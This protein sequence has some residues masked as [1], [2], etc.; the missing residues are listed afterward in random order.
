MYQS[1]R[2][3]MQE[4]LHLHHQGRKTLRSGNKPRVL[5][6]EPKVLIVFRKVRRYPFPEPLESN[7]H[8]HVIIYI[9][10]NIISSSTL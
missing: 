9:H 3:L 4:D 1:T 2:R 8:I 7:R 6:G 10:F 5:R